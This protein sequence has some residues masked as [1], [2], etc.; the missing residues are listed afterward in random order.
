MDLQNQ[1]TRLLFIDNVRVLLILLVIAFHAGAPYAGVY[2]YGIPFETTLVS[3]FVLAWFLTVCLAFFLSLFFMIAG[4][5]TPGSYDRKGSITFL[6]DRIVRLGVPLAFF[7]FVVM[8]LFR[9]V[10][11]CVGS[12]DHLSLWEY[13]VSE[14][15]WE[16]HHLWFI[17]NLLVFTGCYWVWRLFVPAKVKND[18]KIPGNVVIFLFAVLLAVVIFTVRIWYPSGWWD[19]LKL[20]EPAYLPHFAIFFII[21]VIAYRN[22]WFNRMPASVGMAWLRIGILAALLFPVIYVLG[23]GQFTPFAGGFH[24]QP[25]VFAMWEAFVCC[26]FCVGLVVLF[27]ERF[28]GQRKIQRALSSNVYS[29]YLIHILV[30]VSLQYALVGVGLHPI[31]KFALVVALGIPFSFLL[32]YYVVR[33]LPF[34]K[35]IL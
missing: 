25:F 11:Y 23:E 15:H 2:W 4:Y 30:I 13:L 7:F 8:P 31:G 28:N 3:E 29:V 9:Y 35:R 19:P 34:T 18:L 14:Y 6:K 22:D 27:R 17:E 20:V 33:R 21:G 26:G 32:S 10:L 12:Q 5:F 24:W 1:K 16:T